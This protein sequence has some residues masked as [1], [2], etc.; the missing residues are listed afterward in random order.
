[1]IIDF[2][3]TLQLHYYMLSQHKM[4]KGGKTICTNTGARATIYF[5]VFI[6]L[7][8]PVCSGP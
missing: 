7:F 6:S 5:S 2:A 8:L 4:Y 3:V 1:M